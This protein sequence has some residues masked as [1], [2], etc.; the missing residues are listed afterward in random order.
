M[1]GFPQMSGQP[2]QKDGGGCRGRR[3]ADGTR[4]KHGFRQSSMFAHLAQNKV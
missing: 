4:L 2:L 1:T 3:N